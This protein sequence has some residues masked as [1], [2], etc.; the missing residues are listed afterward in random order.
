MRDLLIVLAAALLLR[1]CERRAFDGLAASAPAPEARPSLPLRSAEVP[2]VLGQW[3]RAD[4]DGAPLLLFSDGNARPVAGIRCDRQSGSI[5]IER[6]T[7]APSGGIEAMTVKADNRTRTVPVL[8]DGA[9]LPIAIGAFEF[10]DRLVDGLTR[11][12]GRIEIELGSE[13]LLV[14]PADRKIGA[15]IEECRG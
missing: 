14:L 9:S 6:M 2:L 7:V 15:L 8:W 4:I 1:A 3:R 12:S 11:S 5:L 10:D 13:P